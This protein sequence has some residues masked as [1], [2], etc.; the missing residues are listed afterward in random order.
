MD[1]LKTERAKY[2]LD[3]CIQATINVADSLQK[4]PNL[5]DRDKFVM[6]WDL[7]FRTLNILEDFRMP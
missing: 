7:C 6:L 2:H 1:I 4:Y 3:K 5:E